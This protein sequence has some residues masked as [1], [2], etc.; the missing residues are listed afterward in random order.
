MASA[1]I[2]AHRRLVAEADALFGHRPFGEYTF[3]MSLSD[4]LS[5]SGLEHRASSECGV[6][7]TYFSDWNRSTTE[8]EKI[9]A[10]G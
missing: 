6:R 7:A 10:S 8:H 3:L 5:R 4:Q 2:D 9:R 1:P